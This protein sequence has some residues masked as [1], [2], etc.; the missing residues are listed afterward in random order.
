MTTKPTF[1]VF[2][3]PSYVDFYPIQFGYER[4]KPL[5]SVGPM[6]K[7]HYLFHYIISGKGTFYVTDEQDEYKLSAGQGFLITSDTI[8]SYEADKD[9]PWTYTWIEFDGLKT[10]H[11]LRAAGLSNKQP[12]FTQT[13][14]AETSPLLAAM[15]ALLKSHHASN[16]EIIGHTYLFISKLVE[17]SQSKTCAHQHETKEFYIRESINF[18]ERNYKNKITIEELADQ[19]NLN[20]HYFT[21]LFKEYMQISPLQFLIEYRLSKSCELLANT[22]KSLQEIAEEIGYSNQFN[23]STAFKRRY[24]IS[25]YQ[26]RKEHR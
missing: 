7:K 4:C 15:Q 17:L 10:E 12:I 13:E 16:A 9:Q 22:S 3:N 8:C 20:R 18:I 19:C 26:W 14:P 5:H 24:H 6:M 11:F 25:P 23:Y 2:N 21:R 1:Y